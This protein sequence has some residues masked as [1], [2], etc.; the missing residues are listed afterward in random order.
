MKY[1]DRIIV[2][3]LGIVVLSLAF[4][5]PVVAQV[6]SRLV[7]FP[8]WASSYDEDEEVPLELVEIKVSGKPVV[9]GRQFDADENW[10]KNL[11]LRIKNISNKPITAFGVGGGLLVGVDEELPPHASFRDGIGWRWGKEFDPKKRK[12]EGTVL[13]PGE[14][15]ELTYA[16]VDALTR[17]VLAKEG[18]GAFCKLK[19]M[20]PGV[21]YQDGSVASMPKM[22][23]HG[24][25]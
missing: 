20:A 16:N 5:R 7:T 15:V 8:D 2:A 14:V 11:T 19:F 9:L 18:E 22:R 21:Q 24:K 4:V 12:S 3:S 10:L 6:K 17:K 1:P 23:F 25:P 13:K